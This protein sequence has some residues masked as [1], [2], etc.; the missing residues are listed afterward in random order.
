MNAAL[1]DYVTAGVIDNGD[2]SV[3]YCFRLVMGVP[4]SF[5][6]AV[7]SSEATEWQSAME[8]EMTSWRDNYVFEVVNLPEGR[9]VVKGRWVYTVKD[10]PNRSEQ[11]K[12][13]Y[14][15]KGFSQ[16]EG[17]D[18]HETFA[19]TAKM[20]SIR[21]MVN[22]VAQHD[23][24]VHQLDV[25][26]AYLH[27][28]IDCE[29]YLEPPQGFREGNDDK[30]VWKL[31]KSIYGLKQSGRNWNLMLHEY[32]VEKGFSQSAVDPCLYTRK[33][34][35]VFVMMLVWVDDILIAGTNEECLE[36]FDMQYCK[37][38]KTPCDPNLHFSD[39]DD[40]IV[41]VTRYRELIGSL[42]YAMTCTRPDIC[43][44]VAKLSHDLS[45][46][47]AEHHACAKQV[48]RYIKGTVNYELVYRKSDQPLKVSGY[49]DSD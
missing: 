23:M 9:Y 16:V 39:S 1:D 48:L 5:T 8:R 45:K 19:P 6:E 10:G 33:T 34:G 35:D 17:V 40:S 27:A 49:S 4:Q 11:F 26:S 47:T 41:D 30:A 15:A 43:W 37:P 28:P 13:R 25:K 32:L 12:A 20:T 3:D 14:V 29:L 31:K 42:I 18:Y 24:V 36:R 2:C 44:I 21:T 38:R 22:V 46:P 7:A